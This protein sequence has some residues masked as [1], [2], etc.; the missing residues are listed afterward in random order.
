MTISVVWDVVSLLQTTD[1]LK[2]AVDVD[3]LAGYPARPVRSQEQG[4]VRDVP[5][6]D[7]GAQ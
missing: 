6:L 4:G 5:R 1:A 2:V 7:E 3:D